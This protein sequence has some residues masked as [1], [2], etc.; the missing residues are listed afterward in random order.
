MREKII[1]SFLA[2]F[3]ACAGPRA[4]YSAFTQRFLN[5]LEHVQRE[6]GASVLDAS[7]KAKYL[8]RDSDQGEVVHGFLYVTPEFDP[9]SLERLGVQIQSQSGEICTAVIPVRSLRKL[10]RVKGITYIEINSP[11]QKSNEALL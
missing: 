2:F 1:L 6:N 11:L 4:Q 8:V 9:Q 3:F 10:S 5:D 7:L